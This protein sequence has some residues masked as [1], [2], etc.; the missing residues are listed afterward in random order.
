MSCQSVCN[1]E[2]KTGTLSPKIGK[3]LACT[4][5]STWINSEIYR[6]YDWQVFRDIVDPD[7]LLDMMKS[8]IS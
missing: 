5:I 2:K 3:L 4:E 6:S 1:S 7:V 8:K